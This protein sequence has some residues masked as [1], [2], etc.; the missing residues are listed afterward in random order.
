M[1]STPRTRMLLRGLRQLIA[2]GRQGLKRSVCGSQPLNRR[3]LTPAP[4]TPLD[5]NPLVPKLKLEDES[6]LQIRTFEKTKGARPF[7]PR[8]FFLLWLRAEIYFGLT[9]RPGEK[10]IL[11]KVRFRVLLWK[12]TIGG[13][14]GNSTVSPT[15]TGVCIAA[16]HSFSPFS[17]TR[18]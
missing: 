18:T 17:S 14:S 6:I 13:E 15:F 9:A 2:E 4:Y 3:R 10:M 8:P 16:T 7:R 12:L 11:S 1:I 5:A